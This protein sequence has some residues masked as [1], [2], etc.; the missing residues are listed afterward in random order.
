MELRDYQ[1]ECQNAIKDKYQAGINR[2]L[3][4]LPT[5]T[6]KT[7]IFANLPQVLGIRK[8]IVL[9]HREELLDQAK[10]KI[11][12]ANPHLNVEIEQADRHANPMMTDVLIASVATLGRKDSPRIRRF[13]PDG[14]PLIICDEAH[15]SVAQSYT[16]IFEYFRIF[17]DDSKLLVGV[18][19]TPRRGDKVGLNAVYQEIVYSKDI[20]GMIQAGWLCPI[21]AYRIKTNAD[22]TG[23]KVV[24]GDFVE[25]EL[26]EA[27]NTTD[28]NELAV[29]AYK[30]HCN[31]RRA[32]VFCVDTKHTRDMAQAFRQRGIDCGI[33]LGDTPPDERAET[34]QALA[35]GQIKV[36]ANCMV[37]TEGYDLPTLSAIIMARP[38]KSGL[39]YTQCIGRGTRIH[40]EKDNLIVIDLTDNSRNHQL[41]TLP[42][43]F[44]LPA[45]F[46]LKGRS[47]SDTVDEIDALQAKFPHVP[48]HRAMS[49][50][51]VQK[52]IEQFDILKI[53]QID[54][55]VSEYS[56]NIWIPN[57]DGYAIYIDRYNKIEISQNL[58]GKYEVS[59]HDPQKGIT[60][61]AV[62]DVQTAFYDGDRYLSTN[63]PQCA[64]LLT[65]SARWRGD[66]ATDKQKILL[67]KLGVSY[68]P[69]ITKGQASILIT[70]AF[71][72]KQ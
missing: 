32:L 47:V 50:D 38:T 9:A 14:W 48:L 72:K 16:N 28:R 3:V 60:S 42:T 54:P 33:V 56:K 5:G 61:W 21:R 68:P 13:D 53:T 11:Q 66:E 52:I 71:A 31:N 22:L 6:G 29:D 70:S 58:L 2:Q 26:S 19:A 39:L 49:M 23:V 57:M 24:R 34:L 59:V 15:H 37:L 64:K 20:L 62:N 41:V 43:L 63:F 30:T 10:D 51:E 4:A 12:A 18:T 27:V 45:E 7:V 69:E 17:Q 65:Q 46:E 55:M 35:D 67:T 25:S 40:P 36:V 8:M 1:V 44:G